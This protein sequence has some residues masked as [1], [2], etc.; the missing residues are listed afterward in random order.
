MRGS[1]VLLSGTSADAPRRVD[2]EGTGKLG[3]TLKRREEGKE[4]ARILL[5]LELLPHP[6]GP[7]PAVAAQN[8]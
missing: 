6:A 2:E 7:A 4:R 5:K 8:I 3:K 1:L